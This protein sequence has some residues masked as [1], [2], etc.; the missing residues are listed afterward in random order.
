MQEMILA[1]DAEGRT[2]ALAKILP[3]Q[4]AD[5]VELFEIMAGLPVTIRLLDPPLHEFLPH[6]EAELASVAQ[7]AGRRAQDGAPPARR[8]QGIQP[9]AGPARLPARHPVPRDLRDAGARDLRGGVRRSRPRPAR[10]VVPEVMIPLVLAAREL[11]LI[12]QRIDA[13]AAEVGKERGGA[14]RLSGRHH[15]RAAARG[16]AAPARSPST[17]SS[18]A[19]A[20]TTSPR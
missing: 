9:D 3:M 11:Q 2:K 16:A 13:V 10:T 7:A 5:F 8:S 12:K 19:S 1:D 6:E 20:P 4:R 15:D 18:S 17:P 14:L